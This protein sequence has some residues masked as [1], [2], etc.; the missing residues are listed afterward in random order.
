MY[1][2]LL[3]SGKLWSYLAD[4]NEQAEK[5]LESIIQ[6]MKKIEGVTE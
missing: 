4:L 5:R 3:L 2:E 6:Q 1:Q